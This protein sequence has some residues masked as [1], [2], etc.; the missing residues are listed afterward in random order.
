MIPDSWH[1][2]DVP[3]LTIGTFRSGSCD[4][5]YGETS[6]SRPVYERSVKLLPRAQVSACESSSHCAS[7]GVEWVDDKVRCEIGS[8]RRA[9]D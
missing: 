8:P 7:C 5:L 4:V 6:H 3:A 2:Y 9:V 1:V